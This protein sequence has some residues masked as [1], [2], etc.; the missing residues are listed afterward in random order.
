MSTPPRAVHRL[1]DYRPN[2]PAS[3]SVVVPTF[4]RDD[5]LKRL[6]DRLLRQDYPRDR[7]EI[8]VVDDACSAS[9]PRLLAELATAH[10]D[11]ALR[12]L[13]GRSRG[14]ATARNIG[15]RAARGEVIA[16]IDDDA[17]PA[18]EQWLREGLAPF[19][20]QRAAGAGGAVRVPVSEPPTDF[21]RNVKGLEVGEFLTCNVFY[22]RE[23]LERIGGFDERFTAPYREDSDLQ[24]RVAATGGLLVKSPRAVVV[25]PAVPGRFAISLRLQRYSLFNAL[26]YKKHPER[27]RRDL[28]RGRPLHY[29][30]I[31][32]S[33][34]AGLLALLG[35]RKA[36]ALA[37]G[38]VWVVLEGRFFWRRV[39][40]ASHRPR[41]LLDMALTS[42]LIPYIS[43]YWRL[44]GAVRFRVFFF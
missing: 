33:A 41:H 18:D 26:I 16:F 17:Y 38:G 29:Y 23:V 28:E 24:F 32:A 20:D 31:V 30:A 6:L 21:Q 27:Y 36:V 35:G 4:R 42:L 39:R 37:C 44:R 34:V 13:P 43:I 12:T 8:V 19:A 25:H 3:A 11:V 9:V 5:T 14:P 15:W 1:P 40:G 10:P 22:R 2:E 7:F